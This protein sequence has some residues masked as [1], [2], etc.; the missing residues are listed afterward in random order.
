[1]TG[2]V[3]NGEK[4]GLVFLSG[5]IKS[6][7]APGIPV[8]RIMGMLEEIG[9]LFG[10]ETIGFGDGYRFVFTGKGIFWHDGL[11]IF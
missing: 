9:A 11:F 5:D 7:L 10:E 4:D 8:Y 3:T 2:G 6:L 1:V